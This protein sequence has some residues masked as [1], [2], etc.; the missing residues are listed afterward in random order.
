MLL[1]AAARARHAPGRWALAAAGIGVAVGLLGAATGGG[2]VAGERAARALVAALPAPERTVRVTWNG[3]LPPGVEARG[4]A[5]L[6]AL[7]PGAQT[8]SVLLLATVLQQPRPGR[9]RSVVQLAAIRPLGRWVRLA[10]G[11]LPRSCTAKRCEVLALGGPRAPAVLE[12]DRTRFVTVGRGT[13]RS[14]V[15]LGFVPRPPIAGQIAEARPKALLA[16]GDPAAL[17]AQPALDSVFRSHG[18]SAPL[19][20][21][22]VPSWELDALRRRIERAGTTL[23]AQE[24]GFTV[25][26]P[27]EALGAARERAREARRR[28]VVVG[29]GAAALL[30][31]F[32]LLVA[33]ALRRDLTAERSRLERLGARRWQRG[34]LSLAE[35]AWPAGLG[36]LGGAALALGITAARARGAGLDVRALLGHS[37]LTPG[38][39]LGLAAC[40]VVATGLLTLGA[41][42]R[43]AGA[44]RAGDVLALGA[45]GAVALALSR[46]GAAPGGDD[47]LALLLPPLACLAAGLVVGRLAAPGLG[48]LEAL[49]RRGPL[50]L[51]LAAL[52]LAREP[53]GPALTI[54]V[55]AVSA[56]LACFAA[57]YAATLDR[58]VRDQAAFAVPLDVTITQGPQFVPPL[59][60]AGTARWR[61]LAGGG[62]VLAVK[63]TSV[64]V[65]RGA[66][67]VELPLIGLPAAALPTLRGWRD[68]DAS[69][70]RAV[71]ARRL[72][73]AGAVRARGR[74][75]GAGA[76]TIAAT[77]D[78]TQNS[79]DLVAHLV[80]ADGSGVAVR[81][82][83]AGPARRRLRAVLPRGAA[84]RRLVAL[85]LQLPSGLRATDGHQEAENP[86]SRGVISGR[87]TLRGLSVDGQPIDV[88]GWVGRG[89]AADPVTRA[90]T[91]RAAFRFE[92]ADRAFLRPAQP[93]DGRAIPVLTDPE[94]ARNAAPG[95]LLPI[96]VRG[97]PLRARVVGTVKRFATVGA[98]ADG[99][100]VADESAVRVALSADAPGTGR[101]DELWL[102]VA[103]GAPERRLLGALHAGPL[104]TLR[105][106]SRRDVEAAQRAEPLTR[107]L[108]LTL[109]LAA[110]VALVT[111]AV[112]V[113][114][115]GAVALR[116]EGAA[117]YDLEAL[118]VAPA[119]LRADVRLRAALVAALGLLGGLAIGAGLLGLVVAAV[120]VTATGAAAVPPLVT[121]VPWGASLAV[122][123]GLALAVALGTA[124]TTRR[125]F[126]Q[127]VPARPAGAVP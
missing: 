86:S 111:A 95:G 92:P 57:A 40:F 110:L 72:A 87:L 63:R 51:R 126:G 124:I 109:G 104:A 41:A 14:T 20:A 83:T 35:C 24:D 5:T 60:A 74:L 70:S 31:A 89:P 44:G 122:A 97:T 50:S 116:D 3:G 38:A 12:R 36:C 11:R 53:G 71:L 94:T 13:L 45:A 22:A 43:R 84:G 67:R 96:S 46:G 75:I 114:L 118:G 76:R 29:A 115:A 42:P 120:G 23:R 101:P 26:A 47:P 113:V 18:W 7:A 69:A 32:T 56:G 78:V 17:E 49:A 30:A 68:A 93:T 99:V 73:P 27:T 105:A 52:G 62:P 54:A 81:L 121:V 9:P 125:A 16:S 108:A 37:L 61:E 98:D 59:V 65:P 21:D 107:E 91:T 119:T 88:N 77:A 123:A 19:A 66:R 39:A 90:G 25:E 2:G 100:L 8:S 28:V 112:G 127:D 64:T 103:A 4:R 33:G 79:V 6:R 55:V 58:G 15:P 102:G 10:A 34:A 106:V 85:E 80:D 117:L 1:L 48:G 82:G